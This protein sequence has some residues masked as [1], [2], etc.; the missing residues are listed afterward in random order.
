MPLHRW[1][2][3]IQRLSLWRNVT[4]N[5]IITISFITFWPFCPLIH[6]QVHLSPDWADSAQLPVGR[7]SR[8]PQDCRNPGCH[9]C[10]LLCHFWSL[11]SGGRLQ[12]CHPASHEKWKRPVFGGSFSLPLLSNLLRAHQPQYTSRPAFLYLSLQQCSP[13]ASQITSL[14]L[15][16]SQ[17]APGITGNVFSQKSSQPQCR[18]LAVSYRC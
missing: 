15:P 3:Q 13:R 10:H 6:N 5:T 4:V 2:T 14:P 11:S 16:G 17:G 18:C 8:T 7:G 12:I 9:H 1:Q